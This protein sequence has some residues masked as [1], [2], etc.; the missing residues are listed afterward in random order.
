[1]A[2]RNTRIQKIVDPSVGW[3]ISTSALGA[4]RIVPRS[5]LTVL[6]RA[7]EQKLGW[8]LQFPKPAT[9]A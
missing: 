6:L 4:L 3:H 5:V 9:H 1:M 2:H 7:R 8:R